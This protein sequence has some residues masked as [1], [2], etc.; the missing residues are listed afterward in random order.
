M[1]SQTVFEKDE[2]AKILADSVDKAVSTASVLNAIGQD[3]AQ[4]LPMKNAD[5]PDLDVTAESAALYA[6]GSGGKKILFEKNI[7]KKLPIASVTKLMTALVVLENYDL[8]QK[9]VISLKAV[10]QGDKNLQFAAGE[11]YVIRDLLHFMMVR[12]SNEAAFALSEIS[13]TDRFVGMM[14]Q[15]AKEIGLNNTAFDNPTGLGP[16][17]FST[18]SDL[19]KFAD[20][21]LKNRP[22]IFEMTESPD[23]SLYNASGDLT[24][25]ENN[26]NELLKDSELQGRIIG[27]KTG[28]TPYAKQCLILVLRSPNPDIYVVSAVL[29]SQDRFG[30]TRKMIKWGDSFFKWY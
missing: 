29:K 3:A 25:K 4:D 2:T 21:I 22:L 7:D 10:S 6:F 8:S 18:V 1:A 28:E 11:Q 30:D 16:T 27:G 12:S 17:N 14:N 15:R 9:V 5:A 24:H 20:Y 23:F 13:G 26:I 19:V